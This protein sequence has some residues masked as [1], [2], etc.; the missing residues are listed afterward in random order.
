M[1]FTSWDFDFEARVQENKGKVKMKVC[2]NYV[3]KKE[4]RV[5]TALINQEKRHVIKK[6][7][8]KYERKGKEGGLYEFPRQRRSKR[9][10]SE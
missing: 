9:S 7:G 6:R 4:V 10:Q 8:K 3:I 1:R 5:S 2:I